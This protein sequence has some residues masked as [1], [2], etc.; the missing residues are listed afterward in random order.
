MAYQLSLTGCITACPATC[1]NHHDAEGLLVINRAAA[2]H[3]GC[4]SAALRMHSWSH[5]VPATTSSRGD[6]PFFG[7]GINRG[8]IQATGDAFQQQWA[9]QEEVARR[10]RSFWGLQCWEGLLL[11]SPASASVG[12]DAMMQ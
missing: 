11:G 6:Q 10:T 7:G 4:S 5:A 2:V 12:L 8:C 9:R 1:D 3:Q